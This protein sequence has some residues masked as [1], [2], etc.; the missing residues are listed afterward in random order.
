MDL[1]GI[2]QSTVKIILILGLPSLIVSMIIGLV[3]SIFS[4]VTQVNDAS[5]SFVPKM[6]IVSIFILIT[7]PWVGEH[8]GTY[9]IDLWNN[10]LTF[11]E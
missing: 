7:L 3:I 6:I 5:L 11:G 10:I 2:A 4:A 9:T 8:I 1:I